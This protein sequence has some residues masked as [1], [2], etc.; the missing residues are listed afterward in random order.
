MK[1]KR[2]LKYFTILLLSLYVSS[3]ASTSQL[4]NQD[5][6]KD[7]KYQIQ[8]LQDDYKDLRTK[9]PKWRT[10]ELIIKQAE[11]SPCFSNV[12]VS[13]NTLYLT[14]KRKTLILVDLPTRHGKVLD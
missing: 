6:C 9:K 7:F 3:C 10:E 4:S 11:K 14:Y 1:T 12:Y 13:H 2:V 8:K 5:N